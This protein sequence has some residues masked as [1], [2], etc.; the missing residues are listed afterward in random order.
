MNQLRCPK[1]EA[2]TRG[3]DVAEC[4]FC[5]RRGDSVNMVPFGDVFLEKG[6][7]DEVAANFPQS[8]PPEPKEF[9][10]TPEEVA[11]GVDLPVSDEP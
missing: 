4:V 3:A 5:S 1:C 8:S 7:I 9:F 6:L 11:S 2:V 10:R